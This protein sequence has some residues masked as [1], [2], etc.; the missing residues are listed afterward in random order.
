ML[1]PSAGLKLADITKGPAA[2][3]KVAVAGRAHVLAYGGFCESSSGLSEDAENGPPNNL[4]IKPPLLTSDGL[5]VRY[6][7]R[8]A[9]IVH[10]RL[11]MMVMMA[12][13]SRT[14]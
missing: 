9:V 2:I 5:T 12:A 1:P 6:T 13:S 11:A 14:A 8:A 4:S 7:K 3:S 10:S